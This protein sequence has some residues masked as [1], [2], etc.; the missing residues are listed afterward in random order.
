MI[1]YARKSLLCWR[2]YTIHYCSHAPFPMSLYTTRSV[3][4][5]IT[6]A[7][8]KIMGTHQVS[9][10]I[11][12]TGLAPVRAAW[13]V[14]YTPFGIHVPSH[15]SDRG[16]RGRALRRPMLARLQGRRKARP[17]LLGMATV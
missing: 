15:P 2:R 13:E 7:R 3:E 5:I 9:S 4:S 6:A 1:W 16:R 17:L 10:S 11:V 8:K 14:C 12:G